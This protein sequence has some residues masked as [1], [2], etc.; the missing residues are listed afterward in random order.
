MESIERKINPGGQIC[1]KVVDIYKECCVATV[2][3]VWNICWKNMHAVF[4]LD[5]KSLN[6][7]Y[8]LHIQSAMLVL[9]V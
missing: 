6:P 4:M 3:L 7:M 5:K 1:F 9:L 2:Q 8:R